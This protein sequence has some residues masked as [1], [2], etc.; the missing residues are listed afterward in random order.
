MKNNMQLAVALA[1]G[2]IGTSAAAQTS[3]SNVT[4]YGRINSTVER[5]KIEPQT[6]SSETVT[7]LVNNASRWGIRGT[8]DLGGGMKALFQLESG[9]GSDT[10][11]LTNNPST[12]PTAGLFNREAFVGLSS[13]FGTIRA[14]RITSPLYFATADYI[15]MHNHDTGTSSDTLFNFNATGV[16]NNNTLAYKTPD[17]SGG[18]VEV[19]YSFAAG[20][21]PTNPAGFQEQ[22]GSNNQTNLQVAINWVGGPLHLGGGYAQMKDK[23]GA[24]Q[25]DTDMWVV[26]ALYEIGSFTLG[27]YYE[28]SNFTVG[29]VDT[30][31]G[32]FRLSAMY[33]MGASE[34]HLNYG[35]ADDLSNINDSSANQW[36]LAYNYNLSKRTKVYAFYTQV[37]QD[38]NVDYFGTGLGSKFS[39]FAL[40]LRHNF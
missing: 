6:G 25:T 35:M 22:P 33:A 20:F 12:A 38:A 11:Q 29:T 4:L 10:G 40:G 15:S 2:A 23:T 17:F 26:R 13:S 34:F 28:T 19:A 9:F 37:D 30:D 16:N 3:I 14:G 1:L 8:E 32:N 21:F 27:A 31:R 7:G 5:Q 18:N 39:S 24:P 36:T